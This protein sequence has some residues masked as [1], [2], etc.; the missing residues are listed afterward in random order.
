MAAVPV[1]VQQGLAATAANYGGVQKRKQD[2]VPADIGAVAAAAGDDSD[3]DD[4]AAAAVRFAS[5]PGAAT[6]I[7]NGVGFDHSSWTDDPMR[8]DPSF[9]A[10]HLRLV[11]A[12]GSG[13]GSAVSQDLSNHDSVSLRRCGRQ[14]LNASSRGK[15]QAVRWPPAMCC[16]HG[17]RQD[18]ARR[19]VQQ[20]DIARRQ[21]G[22]AEIGFGEGRK[23]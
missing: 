12:S 9:P 20:A 6:E 23:K 11:P 4:S 15:E 10:G 22:L 17:D 5:A 13:S 2:A 7:E 21:R 3:D 16:S 18:R 1:A 8:L 14:I 19:S